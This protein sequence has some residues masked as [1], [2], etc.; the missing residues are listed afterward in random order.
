MQLDVLHC[1][2]AD[3]PQCNSGR[4][5]STVLQT[6]CEMLVWLL[7]SLA[8]KQAIASAATLALL[9]ASRCGRTAKI[10]YTARGSQNIQMSSMISLKRTA[11]LKLPRSCSSLQ[12]EKEFQWEH[13]VFRH[14]SSQLREVMF[15]TSALLALAAAILVKQAVSSPL[16]NAPTT[17]PSCSPGASQNASVSEPCQRKPP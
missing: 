1:A 5:G 17:D 2:N 7:T 14:F 6:Y 3:A 4:N 16:A 12:I 15:N 10:Q 8:D 11:Q 9:A 13:L